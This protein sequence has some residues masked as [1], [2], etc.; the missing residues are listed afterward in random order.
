MG[1]LDW[2]P[3]A[4]GPAPG[5]TSGLLL[6]LRQ[7]SL[8]AAISQPVKDLFADLVSVESIF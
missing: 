4:T 2:E 1:E 6:D 7:E 8:F 5:P 3:G